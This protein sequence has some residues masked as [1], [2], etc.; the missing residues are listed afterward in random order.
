MRYF[1]VEI[2][3]STSLVIPLIG[4]YLLFTMILVT[5]SVI[6][7]VIT[8]VRIFFFCFQFY[9]CYFIKNV[10]YRAPAT[11]KMS[12]WMRKVFIEVLPYYL[13]MRRP[14]PLRAHL[15]PRKNSNTSLTV[16]FYCLTLLLSYLFKFFQV[17]L[18][19]TVKSVSKR[20]D[21]E[22]SFKRKASSF[23]EQVFIF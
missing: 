14:L 5:L 11:H 7:T 20:R 10:H 1:L 2:I 21:T 16:F 12:A 22:G 6:V 18:I 4:V 15:V 9:N 23:L 19:P 13:L 17:Q 3:P 8:L